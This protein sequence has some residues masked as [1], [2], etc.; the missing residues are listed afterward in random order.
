MC[1]LWQLESSM[2]RHAFEGGLSGVLEDMLEAG[3]STVVAHSPSL[4]PDA[5]SL[6]LQ[7]HD[8]SIA[9]TTAYTARQAPTAPSPFKW[10][11][12]PPCNSLIVY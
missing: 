8:A 3:A 6:M 7:H 4:P 11:P 9:P 12:A 10:Q 2:K 1:P 5:S